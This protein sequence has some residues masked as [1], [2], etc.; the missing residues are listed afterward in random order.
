MCK[1]IGIYSDNNGDTW[2][3]ERHVGNRMFYCSCREHDEHVIFNGL[4]RNWEIV[5]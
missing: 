5:K 1:F 4:P 2:H 3:V